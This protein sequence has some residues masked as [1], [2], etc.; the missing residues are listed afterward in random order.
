M[1]APARLR[2]SRLAGGVASVPGQGRSLPT[3][4]EQLQVL[5]VF[6]GHSTHNQD[7]SH[8]WRRAGVCAH[9]RVRED[10]SV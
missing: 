8:Q 4:A 7:G 10:D 1:E 9:V 5:S 3:S 2:D 6:L